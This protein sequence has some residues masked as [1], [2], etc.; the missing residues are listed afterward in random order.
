MFNGLCC[1]W[2]FVC[3]SNKMNTEKKRETHPPAQLFSVLRITMEE[4]QYLEVCQVIVILPLSFLSF[5]ASSPLSL[6]R[7]LFL[8]SPL[9]L[10]LSLLLPDS[11][12]FYLWKA[13]LISFTCVHFSS[14]NFPFFSPI[15]LSPSVC[16]SKFY[17]TNR[18]WSIAD[19]QSKKAGEGERE[20]LE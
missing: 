20:N 6:L 14:V 16:L 11:C 13:L 10:F 18:Q 7:F 1:L 5:L 15:S 9:P 12:F 4:E 2:V 3:E 17:K 8:P 19:S